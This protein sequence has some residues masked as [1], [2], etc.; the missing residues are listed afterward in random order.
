MFAELTHRAGVEPALPGRRNRQFK[1]A[2]YII[3]PFEIDF[4]DAT[5]FQVVE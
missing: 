2:W 1:I 5:P 3:G 4:S